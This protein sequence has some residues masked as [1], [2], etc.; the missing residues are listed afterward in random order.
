LE[1][2]SLDDV[3]HWIDVDVMTSNSLDSIEISL[4][5][6]F[7]LLSEKLQQS[8]K[9]SNCNFLLVITKKPRQTHWQALTSVRS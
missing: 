4:Q 7:D 3:R 2:I 9:Y 8:E 1:Q 6:E 5:F